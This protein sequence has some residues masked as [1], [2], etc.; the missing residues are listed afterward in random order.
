VAPTFYRD[1]RDLIDEFK[2]QADVQ[3]T[4]AD[5]PDRGASMRTRP[6]PGCARR[7]RT[8]GAQ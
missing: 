3:H 4:S 6:C 8:C 1:Y 7:T 5:A 2:Q